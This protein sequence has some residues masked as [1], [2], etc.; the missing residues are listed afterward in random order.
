MR[1][2]SESKF[3]KWLS[4]GAL[5]VGLYVIVV[6]IKSLWEAKRAYERIGEAEVR[7]Q[8]ETERKNRLISETREATTEAYIEKIA[9]NELNMQKSGEMIVIL[10]EDSIKYQESSIKQADEGKEQKN[11]EKWWELIR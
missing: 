5:I 3:K 2:K 1:V 4:L 10:P 7:L 6:L 11:W 9:R 8:T